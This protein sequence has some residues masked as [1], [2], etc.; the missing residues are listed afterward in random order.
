VRIPFRRRKGLRLD[1]LPIPPGVPDSAEAKVVLRD[2]Y[3]ALTVAGWQVSQARPWPI[4]R[5]V[6]EGY[7][8]IVWVFRA[9]KAYGD[10][11]GSPDLLPFRVRDRKTAEPLD[12]H[13][14]YR[15]MNNRANPLETADI[16]RKRL[17]A[18]ILLSKAGAYVEVTPSRTGT[19]VRLD[20]LPP[21]RT[22]IIPG[23]GTDPIS[24]FE[25]TGTDGVVRP[26]EPDRVRWFRDPHPLD[27]FSG[28]TPLEAAGLSVELDYFARLYNV[29]FMRNDGR[30]GVL[31]AVKGNVP[32]PT[33][34][35]L[36]GRFAPG[37][38]N[39]GRTTVIGADGVSVVDMSA[40]PRDMQY[41]ATARNAK[42]EILAAFFVPE[43]MAG[44]ASGRTFSNADAEERNFYRRGLL[45]HGGIMCSGLVDDVGDDA[46]QGYFDV[47]K[48][49]VLQVEHEQM[50][51]AARKDQEAGRISVDEYREVAGLPAFGRPES[52]A[53]WLPSGRT[54]IPADDADAKELGLVPDPAAAPGA[55][56]GAFPASPGGTPPELPASGGPSPAGLPAAPAQPGNGKTPL[57]IEPATPPP[58][59]ATATR[60]DQP[61]QPAAGPAEAKAVTARPVLRV[62]P[63][64]HR[65]VPGTGGPVSDGDDRLTDRTSDALT[66]ALT[67]LAATWVERAAAK[68]R[69]P[70][71]RTGTRH[72][73]PDPAMPDDRRTGRKALDPAVAVDETRWS[74]EAEQTARPILQD[75]A[76]AAAVLVVADLAGGDEDSSGAVAETAAV[77]ALILALIRRSAARQA[78]DLI[79]RINEL[80]QA[81]D[82]LDGIVAAVRSDTT[83]RLARWARGLAEQA[84]T[85]A[86]EGARS[87]A[88]EWVAAKLGRVLSRQWISRRDDKVRPTHARPGKTNPGGADGQWR[89][90]GE[91]FK[92]GAALLRYPGDPAGPPGETANCRC[93][94]RLALRLARR[95]PAQPSGLSAAA[96][97]LWHLGRTPQGSTAD[98]EQSAG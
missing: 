57:L 2:Y 42:E 13:P 63:D 71:A 74:D 87:A 67:A 64:P 65:P 86:I 48:V 36:E 3:Q 90:L 51:D 79:I 37:P 22:L 31:V 7:E 40:N 25:V 45:P 12:D 95:T 82:D 23:A 58:V 85:G 61:R 16:F 55:A 29:T 62:V 43:S 66:A 11:I 35:K 32:D 53:L 83:G 5:A 92:V 27:P 17:S 19:P 8:R 49:S 6:T 28:V 46:L 41:A 15:L 91:P 10:V 20:L 54:P 30:P 39:A 52:R 44:N 24:H 97:A 96:A 78:F 4:D 94:L 76:A 93:K 38:E 34:R 21:A 69:A 50:L 84:T 81:G 77:V 72:W 18:Q 73:Q 80:D 98:T 88:G 9:T 75:A 56:A 59:R 89:P 1:G 60:L 70:K 26:V 47:A 33:A 14:L 68:I